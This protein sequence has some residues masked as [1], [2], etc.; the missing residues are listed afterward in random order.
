VSSPIRVR[1]LAAT[2]LWLSASLLRIIIVCKYAYR[3]LIMPNTPLPGVFQLTPLNPEFNADPHKL[4]DRLRNECPVMRDELAGAFVLTRY[5]DVRAIV[6]DTSLWRDPSVAE[7]AAAMQKALS[8]R[9]VE[10]KQPVGTAG[11]PMRRR[12]PLGWPATGARPPRPPT[13][14]WPAAG[15]ASLGREPASRIG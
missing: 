2:A 4:L 1:D 12:R 14:D 9:P 8:D 13:Q 6:Q 5:E 3:G 15:Q 11:K 7:E 10:M